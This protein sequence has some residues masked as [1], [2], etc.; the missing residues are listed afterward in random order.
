[1]TSTRNQITYTVRR[2]LL[3]DAVTMVVHPVAGDL[4]PL[5]G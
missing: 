1:L 3:L 4:L 5:L 2:G